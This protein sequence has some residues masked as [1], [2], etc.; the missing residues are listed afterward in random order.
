MSA[1]LARRSAASIQGIAAMKTAMNEK[2]Q[3]FKA[4][5][6]DAAAFVARPANAP[7]MNM[8][9]PADHMTKEL[10]AIVAVLTP[11]QREKLAQKIEQGPPA[12]PAPHV[13]RGR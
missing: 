10:S 11:A 8:G 13:R 7:K 4:D 12:R 9:K 3:S 2:L 5:T 6:F 1:S